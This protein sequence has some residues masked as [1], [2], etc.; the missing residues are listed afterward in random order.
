MAV[1]P[2]FVRQRRVHFSIVDAGDMLRP[3]PASTGLRSGSE[4]THPA[5]NSRLYFL[6]ARR[7]MEVAAFYIP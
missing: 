4:A 5:S 3:N 7:D 2:Q 6:Q 1:V